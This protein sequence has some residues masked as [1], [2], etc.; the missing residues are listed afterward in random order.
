MSVSVP[1]AEPGGRLTRAL[2]EHVIDLLR[3]CRTVR[4]PA[5]FE[6]LTEDVVDGVMRRAVNRGLIRREESFPT[7]LGIDD[8]SIRKGHRYATL[9]VDL[10]NGC[11]RRAGHRCC[12][13]A[14]V[15]APRNCAQHRCGVRHGH[16][17][18]LHRSRTQSTAGLRH[19]VR[20]FPCRHAPQRG[21]G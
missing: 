19:R 11:V 9:L 21:S 16:E 15:R 20:S 5:R 17:P 12:R 6:V 4:G 18:G 2:E 10:D 13:R 3:E 7:S 8:K 1:W 14:S